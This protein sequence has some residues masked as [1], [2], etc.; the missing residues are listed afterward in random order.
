MSR[1]NDITL[2]LGVDARQGR[3]SLALTGESL[4]KF[5]KQTT[6][7]FAKLGKA[8]SALQRS[9]KNFQ[10]LQRDLVVGAAKIGAKLTVYGTAI[11]R[12]LNL[13]SAVQAHRQRLAEVLKMNERTA[14]RVTA[15]WKEAALKTISRA[16]IEEMAT[17]AIEKGIDPRLLSRVFRL[18]ALEA[19]R[20]A[21][22]VQTEYDKIIGR[23]AEGQMSVRDLNKELLHAAQHAGPILQRAG[24]Q[25]RAMARETAQE[26]PAAIADLPIVKMLAQ[27]FVDLA[28]IFPRELKASIQKRGLLRFV[29]DT[30]KAIWDVLSKYIA[31]AG[32][33]LTVFYY[34]N[35]QQ[36]KGRLR[37]IKDWWDVHIYEPIAKKMDILGAKFAAGIKRGTGWETKEG[38]PGPTQ[39]KWEELKTFFSELKRGM[40]EGLSEAEEWAKDAAATARERAKDAAA[41]AREQVKGAAT[42]VGERVKGAAATV[43][44]RA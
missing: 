15:L 41:T 34:K 38:E 18:T 35:E 17:E 2:S 1:L 37:S 4:Q 28:D 40:A 29:F 32:A 6:G 5:E 16:D 10:Q 13:G 27:K 25:F 24:K 21:S 19:E 44:E 12:T 7:V 43:R 11:E 30:L 42:T 33:E 36:I 14:G 39:Q 3:Q 9:W 20:H 31:L 26:T 8:G 22:H 23:L